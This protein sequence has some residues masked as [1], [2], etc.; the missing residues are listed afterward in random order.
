MGLEYTGYTPHNI[1]KLWID[2]YE[3]QAELE[4]SVEFL[5]GQG[6]RVSIYNT[7]LCVIPKNLWKY[8]RK[9]ISDWKNE[10]LQA[11]QKCEELKSCG[12]LFTWNLKM[13]S[14]YTAPIIYQK[15]LV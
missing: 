6:M 1:D 15:D 3:Y 2:P 4:E 9:S 14:K 12:G 7:T 8:A 11:C 10:Y 13:H 5:A